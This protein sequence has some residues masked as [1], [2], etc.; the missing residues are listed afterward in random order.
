MLSSTSRNRSRVGTTR[1]PTLLSLPENALFDIAGY[2]NPPDVYF[3]NQ[4][5]PEVTQPIASMLSGRNFL[6]LSDSEYYHQK[7]DPEV[8]HTLN[9]AT[10]LS[11]YD[12]CIQE[13]QARSLARVL[14]TMSPSVFT[15]E[16][17]KQ[18]AA[19]MRNINN[20]P[21]HDSPRL[22]NTKILMSG[23]VPLQAVL[24]RI[25]HNSEGRV[26]SDVDLFVSCDAIQ[27]VR[28]AM[29]ALGLHCHQVS[30]R[31]GLPAFERSLMDHIEDYVFDIDPDG[32]QASHVTA[33]SLARDHQLRIDRAL[34]P[35]ISHKNKLRNSAVHRIGIVYPG[36]E[37]EDEDFCR[38]H[39]DH[40]FTP[41]ADFDF[42]SSTTVVSLIVAKIGHSPEELIANFDIEAC[43]VYFDGEKFSNVNDMTYLNMSDWN[44]DWDHWINTYLPCCIPK[45]TDISRRTSPKAPI[46]KRKLFLEDRSIKSDDDKLVRI[47]SAFSEAHLINRHCK[48]PCLEHGFQTCECTLV[49]QTSTRFFDTFHHKI[50]KQ[51]LRGLKYIN[52]GIHIHIS[53]EL[54]EAFLGEAAVDKLARNKAKMTRIARYL[55][56]LKQERDRERIRAKRVKMTPEEQAE[57]N[58]NARKARAQKIYKKRQP[59]LVEAWLISMKKKSHKTTDE[60]SAKKPEPMKVTPEK[61]TKLSPKERKELRRAKRKLALTEEAEATL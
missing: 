37:D 57:P 59:D 26:T 43:K 56:K 48:I 33:T 36:H 15:F 47:M 25:F 27:E 4:L 19:A 40:P 17:T 12:C 20:N 51:F 2:L 50:V 42:R 3:L 52:R 16:K 30:N 44:R 38:F 1:S 41:D 45:V 46:K 60:S 5:F 7:P 10:N 18:L 11:I 13:S 34:R 28:E 53:T 35:G 58:A 29:I 49:S 39:P 8:V 32:D 9:A 54:L 23:S 14:N 21:R 61:S 24:G 6:T 22:P 55:Q 31:Y